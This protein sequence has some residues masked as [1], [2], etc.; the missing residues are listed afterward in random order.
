[1]SGDEFGLP[2][3][4]ANGLILRWA[5]SSDAEALA[6][7]N[8]NQHNNPPD[9]QPELWIKDWTHQLMSGD[10]PTTKPAD[11]TVVVN[12]RNQ[13]QIV[14]S[15][16]LVSQTWSY[17][18]IP[19]GLGRPELIATD[20]KWRRR[21]LIKSQMEALHSRSRAKGEMVQ[22]I[23]GIPWFYRQF[24]YEMALNLGGNRRFPF[25]KLPK[26]GN[27]EGEKY[28]LRKADSDDTELLQKLYE[29]SC[30]SS[31]ISCVRD[32]SVWKYEMAAEKK[33]IIT[34]RNLFIIENSEGDPAA[35]AEIPDLNHIALVREF[36]VCRGRPVR[37]IALSLAQKLKLKCQ[38]NA[39][40]L[41]KPINAVTFGFGKAHPIY[42]A[43]ATDLIRT[44]QGYAW[45]LRVADYP[46]FISRIGPVL[47][48]RLAGSVLAAYSGLLKLNF[49]TKQIVLKFKN[50]K[51][52][53][54]EPYEP[55]AFS[56]GDAFFPGLTFLQLLFGYRSLN[57]LKAA[58]PDCYTKEAETP[59]L[60]DILFPKKDSRVV[61][62]A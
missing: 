49:Y 14:S 45:Y 3:N 54:V 7:F 13:G 23:T 20:L 32:Q 57:Q 34:G 51:L 39:E 17:E 8:L 52:I 56:D 22:A 48:E 5:K 42:D 31:M 15:A 9:D 59:I 46:R 58:F 10:H 4:L 55:E 53:S 18:G 27:D 25:D 2:K 44:G 40:K 30:R 62:I 1:M 47:E 29:H 16:G 37:E 28:R 36:A 43:L 19:F 12:K 21:G 11:F 38:Q 60:L 26:V 33:S 35:Y 24:G 61:P 50:G 6:E 41:T